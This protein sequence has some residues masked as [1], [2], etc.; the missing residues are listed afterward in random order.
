MTKHPFTMLTAAVATAALAASLMPA[1]AFADATEIVTLGA[2]LTADQRSTVL[3][4][5]GLSEDDLSN[6]EV[7]TVTN[8]D[9]HS[10]CDASI[11]SSVTGTRTLSC[12]YIQPTTSGGINVETA[13]LTYVTSNT[14]YNA[15]QTAGVENCNL[16]VTAPFEVSGTGALTGVFMAYEAQGYT[17]DEDKA[18][19][20]VEE[21]YET[22]GLE[23]TYGSGIAEA[24]SEVKDTVAS[25]T[26]ELST[27]EIE[28]AVTDA[29]ADQ[30]ITLS[31]DDL[32]TLTSLM[33]KL[34]KL[35]YDADAFS[36]TLSDVK[37]AL[38]NAGEQAD[39]ILGALQSFFSNIANF[40]SGLFG[41]N[42]NTATSILDKLDT[43]VFSLDNK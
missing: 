13:N 42:N 10:Y 28:Q 33:S 26:S 2:D 6:V 17:I 18:T 19:V 1:A 27:E 43:S 40:F 4:F 14:L 5:F 36:N 22:A 3:S 21:M 25:S 16:V 9:E 20:A 32:A 23:D 41:G 24:V 39:G 7:I 34:Q 11:P 38:E 8:A 35:D 12:S 31:S 15:L 30:G 29:A 37:N